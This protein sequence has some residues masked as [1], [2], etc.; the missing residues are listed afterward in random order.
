MKK[1]FYIII[2]IS[3][4][5]TSIFAGGPW[6]KKQGTGFYKIAQSWILADQHFTDQGLLDPNTT[7]GTF[8]TSIYAEY[9]LTDR[10]TGI[11]YAPLFVR[12]LFYN[13]ISGTTG[14]LLQAGEAINATGDVDVALQ[15]GLLMDKAVSLSASVY[16]GFPTGK[17]T[18]GSEGNLQT[19]DGEFNQM[20]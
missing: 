1:S 20:L 15:Y 10:L 16:L 12:S 4:F 13:T 9:G 11:V 18:G 2:A 5:S 14:D 19:G 3:L 17:A 8:T 6:P 7:F